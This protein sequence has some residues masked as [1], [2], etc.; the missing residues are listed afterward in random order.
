MSKNHPTERQEQ[1]CV[2]DWI[3]KVQP[4]LR[5]HTIKI[6]NE[7]KCSEFVGAKLNAQG[8]L[9]G[10][11]DLFFAWPTSSYYGLFIEM[12]S[13]TGKPT[14]AQLVFIDRMNRVGYYACVANGADAAINIIKDYLVNKL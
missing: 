8:R 14:Q 1:E 6:H 3:C 10:A 11:S 5:N 2:I 9:T 12:K 4:S 13:M 7:G